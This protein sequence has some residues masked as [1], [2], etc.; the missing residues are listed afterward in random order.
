MAA[1]ICSSYQRCHHDRRDTH[2]SWFTPAA[3]TKPKVAAPAKAYTQHYDGYFDDAA[4]YDDDDYASTVAPDSDD[5][6]L[7]DEVPGGSDLL[8]AE[9]NNGNALPTT[10][11]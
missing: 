4:D 3:N 11:C 2:E 9:A 1:S 10:H 7:D 8:S 6:L 5:E